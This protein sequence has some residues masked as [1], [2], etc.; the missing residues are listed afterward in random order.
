MEPVK[1]GQRLCCE[2][3]GVELEVVKDCDTSCACNIICC[4]HPMKLKGRP[5]PAES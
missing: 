5:E 1:A 4:D 3:C 2:T